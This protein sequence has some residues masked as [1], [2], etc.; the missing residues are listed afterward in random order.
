MKKI[1]LFVAAVFSLL[2]LSAQSF[3]QSPYSKDFNHT[4]ASNTLFVGEDAQSIYLVTYET[5][6]GLGNFKPKDIMVMA[7][8]RNLK[9]QRS[10]VFDKTDDYVIVTAAMN[11][12]VVTVLASGVE[13]H[14]L[15]LF[16]YAV[17]MASMK[18]V[19][20]AEE[21]L[22]LSGKEHYKWFKWS[23]DHQ[24]FGFVAGALTP[25]KQ[26]LSMSQ[27]LFDANL[28]L[29]WKQE[30]PI[31]AVS[32][33]AVGNDG[34]IATL[35]YQSGESCTRFLFANITAQGS[36][37]FD[38]Q[39]NYFVDPINASLIDYRNGLY[40][41]G[42]IVMANDSPNDDDCY[43]RYFGLVYNSRSGQLFGKANTFTLEEVNVLGD[44]EI[45]KRQKHLYADGLVLNGEQSTSYGGALTIARKYLFLKRDAN[46]IRYYTYFQTGLLS[47][48]VDTLGNVMWHKPIRSN[49]AVNETSAYANFASF[50][51]NDHYY[52]L[53][54]ESKKSPAD[55]DVSEPLKTVKFPLNASDKLACYDIAPDGSVKKTLFSLEDKGML[56]PCINK[57]GN[58]YYGTLSV[59]NKSILYSLEVK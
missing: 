27:L 55:Y 10:F 9:E 32:D 53:L 18:P 49:L 24:Y 15:K 2:T 45:D 29:L 16:R 33:I 42:G 21:L 51:S 48:G 35:G 34:S 22:S 19:T 44:Q 30:N 54:S 1:T 47:F 26:E 59:L 4:M 39:Y 11:G 28:Q 36:R 57:V 37:Q 46:G 31:S 20:Q 58:K 23:S 40:I 8:D 7:V 38:A 41:M 6:T 17:N 3:T 52:L 25:K 5:S 50:T 12:D 56:S 43:D 13:D 14:Q